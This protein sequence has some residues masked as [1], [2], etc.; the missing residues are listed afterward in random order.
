LSLHSEVNTQLQLKG[1]TPP[2][3]GA[4]LLFALYSAGGSGYVRFTVKFGGQP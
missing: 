1:I 4:A 3:N 2:T